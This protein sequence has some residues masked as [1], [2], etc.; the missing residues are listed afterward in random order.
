MVMFPQYDLHELD[1]EEV[2]GIRYVEMIRTKRLVMNEVCMF[3]CEREI[4]K[5]MRLVMM[6]TWRD[7]W[8]M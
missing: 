4:R 3:V 2:G 6:V 5:G 7:K 1:R 8:E